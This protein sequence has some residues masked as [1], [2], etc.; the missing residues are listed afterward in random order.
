MIARDARADGSA[1]RTIATLTMVFL[2]ATYV[3]SVFSTPILQDAH[4]RL[5][6]A[7]TIP[8]TFLVFL[9]WWVWQNFAFLEGKL[10][11]EKRGQQDSEKDQT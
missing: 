6:V 2:P 1:M 10:A 5:Y 3:S 8:L 11:W 4:W 7:I 9:V